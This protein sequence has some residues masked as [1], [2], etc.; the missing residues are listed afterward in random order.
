ME[1]AGGRFKA[2]MDLDDRYLRDA[3]DTLVAHWSRTPE[4]D[5]VAYANIDGLSEQLDGRPV[6]ARFPADMFDSDGLEIRLV[7]RVRSDK[8]G[9]FRTEVLREF[10]FPEELGRFVDEG[11]VWN[12]ID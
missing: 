3:L 8:K 9:M 7:H 5:Q 6:G 4:P 12:R 10:P 1:L 2:V 11:I